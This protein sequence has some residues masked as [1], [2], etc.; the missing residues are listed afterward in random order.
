MAKVDEKIQQLL[1]E[2]QPNAA[3]SILVEQYSERLYWTIRRIV[4]FH[5][6]ADDVLQ[7]TFVKVWQKLD[8]FQWQSAIYTW[9]HKIAVNESLLHL[10]KQKKQFVDFNDDEKNTL[11]QRLT[12]DPLFN[13]DKAEIELQKAID[14]LPEKQRLVFLYRYYEEMSYEQISEILETSKGGLRA[15]YHHA[16]QKIEDYLRKTVL[17]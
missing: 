3:F 14:D 2:Q 17:V 13:G 10:R 4:H 6:D 12:A 7:N 8:Q 9:M 16:V 1:R 5:E 11:E 15:S